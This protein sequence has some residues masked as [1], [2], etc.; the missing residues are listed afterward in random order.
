[1]DLHFSEFSYGYAVTEEIARL[2]GPL[3]AAPVFPSLAEEGMAGRGYD[4]RINLAKP[5]LPLFLQFKLS[6]YISR[7]RADQQEAPYWPG[8]KFFRV[9]LRT[10]RPNQ[11]QLLL[12][13]EAGGNQVYYVAPSFYLVS[14]L[15]A[16][17]SGRCVLA[18]SAIVSPG[19]LGPYPEGEPHHFSFRHARD[20]MAYKFSEPEAFEFRSF[21][22]IWDS[23]QARLLRA[24][25]DP[26]ALPAGRLL[27]RIQFSMLEALRRSEYEGLY[28][29]PPGQFTLFEKVSYL[30]RV[31]FDATFVLVGLPQ[32]V[33]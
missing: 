31:A 3:A 7:R 11:H 21:A 2:G 24:S 18:E 20:G 25:H 19:T 30:A 26:D 9:R 14:E 5:A 22:A 15:N 17:Y 33:A 29:D 4:V 13:L 28:I 32:E 1:M 16:H 12:D 8:Q 6:Q 23:Y 10:R 27:E